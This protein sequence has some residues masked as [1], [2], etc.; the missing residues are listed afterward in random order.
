MGRREIDIT[1]ERDRK[2]NQSG[3]NA[4]DQRE[5]MHLEIFSHLSLLMLKAVMKS[6]TSDEVETKIFQL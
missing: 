1:R 5:I 2:D 6:I 3:G 4:K